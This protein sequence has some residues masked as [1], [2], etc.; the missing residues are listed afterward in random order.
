MSG[1]TFAAGLTKLEEFIPKSC[2]STSTELE[3]SAS[4]GIKLGAYRSGRA[5]FAAT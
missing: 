3:H 5:V 2:D 4:R 1:V